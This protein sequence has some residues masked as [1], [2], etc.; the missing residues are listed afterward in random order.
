MKMQNIGAEIRVVHFLWAQTMIKPKEK[1]CL[2]EFF[3]HV[4]SIW[5]K[6]IEINL[7]FC[8]ICKPNNDKQPK[9]SLVN[10]NI[11]HF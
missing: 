7:F 1:L 2:V 9:L 5:F 4:G 8:F 11:C 6:L 10:T 3:D